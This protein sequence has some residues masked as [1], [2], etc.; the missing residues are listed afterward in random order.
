MIHEGTHGIHGLDLLGRKV[1]MHEGA[2]LRVLIDAM[3]ASIKKADSLPLSSPLSHIMCRTVAAIESDTRAAWADEDAVAA[4]SNAT[5][6]LKAVGH[7]VITWMWLELAVTSERLN[8][9]LTELE[10]DFHRGKVAAANYFFITNC[11]ISTYGHRSSRR[12]T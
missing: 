11:P 2:G 1:R 6:Y 9:V 8:E 5:L 4:L 3:N 12:T 7:A 10:R